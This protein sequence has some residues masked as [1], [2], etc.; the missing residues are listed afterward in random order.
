MSKVMP[1]NALIGALSALVQ[2]DVWR[3]ER[4][5]FELADSVHLDVGASMR[6]QSMV[7]KVLRER[8]TSFTD[9]SS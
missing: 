6:Q 2:R 5:A 8:P 4:M 1:A 9:T 3:D 7:G